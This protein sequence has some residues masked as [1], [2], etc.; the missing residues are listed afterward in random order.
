MKRIV[1]FL[2]ALPLSISLLSA[3]DSVGIPNEVFYLMPKMTQ[4]TLLFRDK[5]PIPGQ[6]NI[7]AV[8]NTVR[9]MDKGTELAMED[10]ESMLE[11]VFND[12]AFLHRDGTY[13]RLYPVSEEAFVAVKRDVLIM[14]D[15]KMGSYGMESNTTAIQTIE[16]VG[17]SIAGRTLNLA[18]MK[19]VPYRM[20]ETAALYRKGAIISLNKRN[21]TRCFPDKKA[22]IEAWFDEHKKIDP[23]DIDA[24][25]ELCKQWSGK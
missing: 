15:S 5:S 18:D 20:T 3:Q 2:A 25:L 4:G 23:T 11:V 12:V 17:A 9:F 21:L 8:D 13:Y 1:S 14:N 16:G 10:D 7:C 6:F 22:D 24:V 19:E